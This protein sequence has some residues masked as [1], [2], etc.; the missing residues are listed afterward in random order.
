MSWV[1]LI[2]SMLPNALRAV[3]CKTKVTLNKKVYSFWS[4][5]VRNGSV[6]LLRF[7]TRFCVQKNKQQKHINVAEEEQLFSPLSP[8]DLN[9]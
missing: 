5:F 8:S 1:S 3:S 9:I 6:L 7:L 2:Y 4:R